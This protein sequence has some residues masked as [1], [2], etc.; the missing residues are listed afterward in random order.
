MYTDVRKAQPIGSTPKESANALIAKL[1]GAGADIGRWL[2]VTPFPV[3]VNT[4]APVV[5]GFSW[6]NPDNG[7]G[8]WRGRSALLKYDAETFGAL[9]LQPEVQEAARDGNLALA[10]ALPDPL[11]VVDID[12]RGVEELPRDAYDRR[13]LQREL[14]R[15]AFDVLGIPR[16]APRVLSGR[17]MHCYVCGDYEA[18]RRAV[19]QHRG[20]KVRLL[21]QGE[22]REFE[23]GIE[24]KGWGRG[25]VLVP[26]SRHHS[27]SCYEWLTE[28]PRSREAIPEW[29]PKAPDTSGQNGAA[30]TI[31]DGHGG[32]VA[33][34]LGQ[35]VTVAAEAP[36]L[37]QEAIREAT[38]L[39]LPHWKQGRRHWL[40]LCLAGACARSGYTQ[41]QA[42]HLVR[43]VAERARDEE[44][45]DRLR[46]VETT[47]ERLHEGK[48]VVGWGGLRQLLGDEA[49]RL[50]ALLAP[51]PANPDPFG[52]EA[53]SAEVLRYR[54]RER[55]LH[56]RE[57]SWINWNG[58]GW[59]RDA[60]GIHT[61]GMAQ[62]IL[63]THY[64]S[65]AARTNNPQEQAEAHKAAKRACSV[66][67]LNNVLELLKDKLSASPDEFDAYTYLLNPRNCV[68]DLRDG[69]TLPHAPELRLT[70]LCPTDY[71]PDARSELWEEFLQAVFLEDQELIAYVQRAL[72]YSI[73]GE[74][75][76]QKLF[77]C[78]GTGANGKSTLFE[79]LRG[80]LGS[81]YVR[82]VPRRALLYDDFGNNADVAR[83]VLR[84]V[85]LGLFS[86]PAKGARLDEEFV[87]LISGDEK[88]S[89]RHLYQEDFEYKPELKLW[90]AT[91][92]KPHITEFSPAMWRRLVLIPFRAVFRNDPNIDP[93]VR[94]KPN[95]KIKK[96]LLKSPHREAILAWLVKGAIAW[97]QNGLQEPDIVRAAVE[98]YRR[99]SDPVQ[100]W[101]EAETVPDPNARTPVAVLYERYRLWCEANGETPMYIRSFGR[102]LSEMGYES[103]RYYENG[104]ELKAYRGIRLR[105]GTAPRG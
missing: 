60:G 70:K 50:R 100:E 55:V 68:V 84:G 90:I 6:N 80:V 96:E 85:R 32:R 78:Y 74:T 42:A 53:H 5:Q 88:I 18:L 47:Y 93:A 48:N 46:A 37:S 101:L 23:V 16:E 58:C 104:R 71:D 83:A 15:V 29:L 64:T 7:K 67:Y 21:V 13:E 56:V 81:D 86:D 105:G 63:R 38:E 82:T 103:C 36:K 66:R 41:E 33:D 22:L 73:T 26:P 98:E 57:W 61:R 92:H 14:E 12:A 2:D 87:K 20:Q 95:P 79:V 59:K 75:E 102:R 39:L 69:S 51:E 54:L 11:G 65:L 30:V 77:I 52:T 31:V 45:D 72:G 44:L 9:W 62:N 76:E 24:L 27:G 1:Y 40:A 49:D 4:K 34:P 99:E 97:Y 8:F 28:V 3:F 10:V 17:G 43:T 35:P 89:A 25:Y 91:N 94:R 19:A